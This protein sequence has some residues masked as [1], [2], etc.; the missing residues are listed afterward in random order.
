MYK[1][2]FSLA[3]QC[4]DKY[5]KRGQRERQ[6]QPYSYVVLELERQDWK[7]MFPHTNILQAPSD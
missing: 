5:T 7:P 1:L 4:R 6:T 2:V 3:C